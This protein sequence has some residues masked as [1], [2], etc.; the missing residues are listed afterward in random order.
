[1][2]SLVAASLSR[3]GPDTKQRWTAQPL[4]CLKRVKVQF[5]WR[6][7]QLAIANIGY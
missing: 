1:M 3:S 2:H 4:P 6:K 5:L 7:L